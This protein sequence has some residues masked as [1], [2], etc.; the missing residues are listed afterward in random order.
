VIEFR[1]AIDLGKSPRCVLEAGEG[2]AG[3]GSRKDPEPGE[4]LVSTAL[5]QKEVGACG[6]GEKGNFL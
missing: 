6:R 5:P 2:N 1:K 3:K 4:E